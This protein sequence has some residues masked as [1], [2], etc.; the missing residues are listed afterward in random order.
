MLIT[1]TI[2][3]T[4]EKG[5]IALY[6]A[7]LTAFSYGMAYIYQLGKFHYYGIPSVFIE[8]TLRSLTGAILAIFPLVILTAFIYHDFLKS[9][10]NKEKS[11]IPEKNSRK[12]FI[13][14]F[15]V[16]L[17]YLVLLFG[18]TYLLINYFGNIIYLLI[19]LA[20]FT[21]ILFS[22]LRRFYKRQNYIYALFLGSSSLLIASYVFG[23]VING[24]ERLH[25]IVESE[26]KSSYV[27]VDTY[28]NK[29]LL[30][31]FDIEK[32]ELTKEFVLRDITKNEYRLKR[33]WIFISKNVR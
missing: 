17:V 20:L 8:L 29:A 31:N 24:M 25:T 16:F 13:F 26:N 33:E 11:N 21:P 6:I 32:K 23:V 2:K 19:L 9:L 5:D 15:V 14:N 30:V 28:N 18:F 10:G 12:K 4:F 7:P 1:K 22:L 27:L 3:P